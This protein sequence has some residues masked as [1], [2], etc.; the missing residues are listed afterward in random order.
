MPTPRRPTARS[1]SE[2]ASGGGAGL[3]LLGRAIDRRQ[4]LGVDP[5]Q[6]AGAPRRSPTRR[7][8]YIGIGSRA[9]PLGSTSSSGRYFAGSA[10][11]V[12]AVAV[13]HRPRR[14]TDPRRPGPDRRRAAAVACTASASLPSTRIDSR[15]YAD[16]RSAAGCSTAV[17]VADRRVLHVEVVLADEDDRQLPDRGEVQRL[18]ERADVRGPVAEEADRDLPGAARLRRP[19][20]AGRDRHVRADDGVRAHRAVL[21]VGEVHRPALAAADAG[22]P[23][24]QLG[25]QPAH[26]RAAQQRVDVAA[27]RAEDQ[28]V[29]LAARRRTRRRRPP[30]PAPGATSP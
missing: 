26:R 15:P 11:R 24:H 8:R 4:R 5:V 19:R 1:S 25:H 9:E 13:R 28:V 30:G 12:A 3:R 17:T 18:V 21:D 20:G 6:H 23:A 16:A 29:R 10:R 22:R 27:I 2:A 7:S 14:A